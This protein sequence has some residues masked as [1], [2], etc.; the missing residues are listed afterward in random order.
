MNNLKE[1]CVK[2]VTEPRFSHSAIIYKG[3]CEALNGKIYIFFN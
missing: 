3:P 2:S 1:I